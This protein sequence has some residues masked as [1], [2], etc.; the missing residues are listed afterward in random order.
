MSQCN[1]LLRNL[2]MATKIN[3]GKITNGKSTCITI[4]IKN[5]SLKNAKEKYPCST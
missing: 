5:P 3:N 2:P 4:R 1:S